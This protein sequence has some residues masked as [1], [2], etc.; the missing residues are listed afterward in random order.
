MTV[1]LS[2]ATRRSHESAPNA[3][4]AWIAVIVALAAIS[5]VAIVAGPAQADQAPAD[6]PYSGPLY[7]C[8]PLPPGSSAI[9]VVAWRVAD[10]VVLAPAR[11]HDVFPSHWARS[12]ALLYSSPQQLQLKAAP[13]QLLTPGGRVQRLVLPEQSFECRPSA[14][15]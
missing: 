12:A 3:R 8:R 11:V 15:D 9:S 6:M 4:L 14:E 5:S 2:A 10:R 13:Q 7:L 1:H